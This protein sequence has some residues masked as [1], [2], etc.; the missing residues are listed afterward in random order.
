MIAQLSAR[1]RNALLEFGKTRSPVNIDRNAMLKLLRLGLVEIRSRGRLTLT[2]I[3]L[4]VYDEL[5]A[6]ADSLPAHR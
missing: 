3:G 5:V 4:D 2:D 1:E 6:P